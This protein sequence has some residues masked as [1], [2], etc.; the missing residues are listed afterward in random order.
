M[1]YNFKLNYIYIY[2][3]TRPD[4]FLPATDIIA[5]DKYVI[6]MDVPGISE[7]DIEMYR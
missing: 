7:E 1:V 5:S 6:Y 3:K 2:S 4:S